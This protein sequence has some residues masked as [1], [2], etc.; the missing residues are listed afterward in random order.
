MVKE[1]Q[2]NHYMN[3]IKKQCKKKWKMKMKMQKKSMEDLK[4][5]LIIN[6]VQCLEA[7]AKD[8]RLF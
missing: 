7:E 2:E 1:E 6:Y 8:L 5:R 4:E 3:Y